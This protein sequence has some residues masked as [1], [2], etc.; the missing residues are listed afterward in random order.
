[1][2]KPLIDF[3]GL[4]K[5]KIRFYLK[6]IVDINSKKEKLI[7]HIPY[8][9]NTKHYEQKQ[10]DGYML[11]IIELEK[12]KLKEN[13]IFE[14]NIGFLLVYV[15]NNYDL[16]DKCLKKYLNKLE[17][18]STDK[19]LNL[20]T[21]IC[22]QLLEDLITDLRTLVPQAYLLFYT[23]IKFFI[24]YIDINVP[25][26]ATAL[27]KE[28]KDLKKMQGI[29]PIDDNGTPQYSIKKMEHQLE[30][31]HTVE[32]FKNECIEFVS[33]FIK[34]LQLLKSKIDIAFISNDNSKT[35]FYTGLTVSTNNT[36]IYF[37]NSKHPVPT[38]YEYTFN[39]LYEFVDIALYQLALN[40]KVISICKNCG[41]YFIPQSRNDEMYCDKKISNDKT[42]K[43]VGKSRQFQKK[44][45]ESAM[46]Y[47]IFYKNLVD[48][49]KNPKYF[50]KYYKEF[51]D[52]F[53]Q[54]E[55]KT[56]SDISTKEQTLMN[57]LIDFDKEFQKKYPPKK[58]RPYSTQKY[59]SYKADTL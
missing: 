16:V 39:E 54:L 27:Y 25:N 28:L 9:F 15:F 47:K 5:R 42:C 43:D 11:P 24:D 19:E 35:K 31:L 33:E 22:I 32:F 52:S 26:Y 46:P 7:Q 23:S 21:P 36:K 58:G 45:K 2:L 51:F 8:Y 3:P 30:E 57:F 44:Q 1:M 29:I 59:W 12:P 56:Y 40:N 49:L 4:Y 50:D 41:D 20:D 14:A 34:L 37:D 55:N 6:Y 53:R 38:I 18:S 48:R 10:K 17:N 13:I